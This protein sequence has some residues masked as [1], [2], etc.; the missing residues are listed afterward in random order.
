MAFLTT[1]TYDM[2]RGGDT[3]GEVSVKG[4]DGMASGEGTVIGLTRGGAVREAGVWLF[5]RSAPRPPYGVPLLLTSDK[6]MGGAVGIARA[7]PAATGVARRA[8]SGEA[9]WVVLARPSAS[10][11]STCTRAVL[12]GLPLCPV[13]FLGLRSPRF[14]LATFARTPVA[15]VSGLLTTLAAIVCERV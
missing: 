3:I 12:P 6:S 1:S 11:L 5:L 4:G 8:E 10:A 14:A 9:A 13:P 15:P 2:R 7:E